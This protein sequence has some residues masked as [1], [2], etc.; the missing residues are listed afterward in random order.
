MRNSLQVVLSFFRK[1]E[2][3]LVIEILRHSIRASALTARFDKRRIEVTRSVSVPVEAADFSLLASSFGK[4]IKKFGGGSG[5]R[6]IC[7]AEPLFA[8]TVHAAVTLIREHDE[9]AIDEADLDNLVGQAIWKLLDRHRSQAATKMDVGDIDVALADVRVRKILLDGHKVVNPVGFKAKTV[10]FHLVQTFSS[11]KF[12]HLLKGAL[13]HASSVSLIENGAAYANVVAKAEGVPDFLLADVF[14]DRTDMF[15]CDRGS[16]FYAD[17]FPWGEANMMR[18]LTAQFSLDDETAHRLFG[19]YLREEAS[20]RF[21]RRFEEM[22]TEE[23][24]IMAHGFTSYLDRVRSKA[25]YV[26]AFFALPRFVFS[27]SFSRR[28]SRRARLTEV[29]DAFLG[30]RLGFVVKRARTVTLQSDFATVAPVLEFYFSP[31]NDKIDL[32][33]G[34]HT[35]WLVNP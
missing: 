16:L 35:R 14:E 5:R 19:A 27:P 9:E 22:L 12:L 33:V 20:P 30:D 17:S 10:E 28:M 4:L 1:G 6:I 26:Q 34:R 31:L 21:L 11:K 15:Y 3:F 18:S 29:T 2:R 24:Q 23:F 25:V 7:S 32:M 8:T 13:P